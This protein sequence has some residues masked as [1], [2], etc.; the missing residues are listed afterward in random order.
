MQ[1]YICHK[2]SPGVFGRGNRSPKEDGE[3]P[4]WRAD[5]ELR[6]FKLTARLSL[7]SAGIKARR[8]LLREL[9]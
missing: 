7:F 5:E 1:Q 8:V 6:K 2:P 3:C 4:E 9:V